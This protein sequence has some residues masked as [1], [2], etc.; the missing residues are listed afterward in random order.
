MQRKRIP[1]PICEHDFAQRLHGQPP[2]RQRT[3][4]ARLLV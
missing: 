4:S 2:G 1:V 3:F